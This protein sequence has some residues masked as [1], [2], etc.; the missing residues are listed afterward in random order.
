MRDPS[1]HA[2]TTRASSS[3]ARRDER[4]GRAGRG[5]R[6]RAGRTRRAPPARRRGSSGRA[7]CGRCAAAA[8][9]TAAASPSRHGMISPSSTVPSGRMLRRVRDLGKALRHQLLAARPDVRASL[10]A[11]H[12]RADAVPLPLG[13][14]LV[15]VAERLELALERVGE[16]E[17][18][19]G[20][21]RSASP[22]SVATSALNAVGGRRPV[23]AQP[24]RDRR[25]RRRRSPARARARRAARDTPTRKP[26]VISLFQMKRSVPRELAPCVEHDDRAA[27]RHRREHRCAD[28]AAARSL[29]PRRG[30]ACVRRSAAHVV[31]GSSSAIVSARSPTAGSTPRTA[32]PARPAPPSPTSA[33]R[34]T[35]ISRFGRPPERK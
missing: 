21:T 32:S 11:D 28:A 7:S 9:R 17:R 4:L 13:L 33:S 25:L 23:S 16:V 18:D 24:V 6:A 34:R 8:A 2:S 29:D 30:A 10:A 35:G 20:A 22:L 26:P 15:G 12:L 14:P 5:R 1:A 31:R 27:A 19:T 3:A